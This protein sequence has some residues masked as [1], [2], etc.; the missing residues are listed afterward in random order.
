MNR[1]FF[2]G[3]EKTKF[4]HTTV[5]ALRKCCG[6]VHLR[7]GCAVACI[8][9]ATLSMYFAIISFQ[10]RSPFFSFMDSTPLLIWGTA[11]LAL[12]IVAMGSL[13]AIYL[14]RWEYIRTA[15]HAIIVAIFFVVADTIVNVIL[16]ATRENRYADSC[17]D[18]SIGQLQQGISQTLNNSTDFTFHFEATDYYNCHRTW[19][20]E[21]KFSIMTALL[22]L[23]FYV[24]WAMCLH[25]LSIKKWMYLSQYGMPPPP[26][27]PPMAPLPPQPPMMMPP[28]GMPMTNRPNVIVLNNEKPSKRKSIPEL[29]NPQPFS[30]PPPYFSTETNR[31]L[32]KAE[33]GRSLS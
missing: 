31:C 30:P 15:C 29:V 22:M 33:K 12:S 11:N 1:F 10:T 3:V 16:F 6:C 23:I 17:M 14:N 8:I 25:S 20:S 19:E 9:W 4:N 32:D 27:E 24:Y 21:V 13:V 28:T 5:Q 2:R 26:M 18:S 7:F